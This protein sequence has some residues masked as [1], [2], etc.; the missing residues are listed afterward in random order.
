MISR[1]GFLA[2]GAGALG[3]AVTAVGASAANVASSLGMGN[4][5][6]SDLLGSDPALHLIRRASF[7]PTPELVAEVRS[8]GAAQVRTAFPNF[9]ATPVGI[10]KP[11][12]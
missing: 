11:S 9:S 7:G 5:S 6:S 10:F 3:V 1:R 8:M 2:M 4:Y 12:G